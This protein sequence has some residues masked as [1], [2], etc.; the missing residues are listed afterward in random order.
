ML[1]RF[2]TRRAGNLPI[3]SDGHRLVAIEAWTANG[4]FLCPDGHK[5]AIDM[6]V[7]ITSLVLLSCFAV[8]GFVPVA[9]ADPCDPGT[10]QAGPCAEQKAGE[11]EDA[12]K[13]IDVTET[14][15]FVVTTAQNTVDLV[16][17]TVDPDGRIAFVLERVAWAR[18]TADNAV[19]TGVGIVMGA[20]GD[21]NQAVCNQIG[22]DCSDLLP[23]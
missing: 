2:R 17:D 3:A 23:L 10:I 7:K 6:N 19:E 21:A 11:V 5:E 20:Y 9:A 1:D 4:G 14:V 18:Q 13:N 22:E 12:I 16:V 15:D 8:I